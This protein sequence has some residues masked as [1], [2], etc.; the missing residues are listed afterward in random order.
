[1]INCLLTFQTSMKQ[2]SNFTQIPLR[3]KE[4]FPNEIIAK[5]NMQYT[6]KKSI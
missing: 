4:E 2:H 6:K 5:T 1:M 3:K